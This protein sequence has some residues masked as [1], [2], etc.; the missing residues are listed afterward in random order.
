L[1]DQDS[2]YRSKQSEEPEKE[3]EF[4]WRPPEIAVD[5]DAATKSFLAQKLS[6]LVPISENFFFCH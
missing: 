1:K 5:H 3:E 6:D 2:G 4:Y